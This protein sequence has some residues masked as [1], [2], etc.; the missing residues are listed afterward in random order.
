MEALEMWLWRRMEK[1]SWKDRISNEVVL[2]RVGVERELINMLR[3]KKKRWIGHVLR[4]D[5]LLKEVIGARLEGNKA[6]GRPRLE[7]LDDLITVLYV[8]MKQKVKDREGW[9][10]YVPWTLGSTLRERIIVDIIIMIH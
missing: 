5:G 6:R 4:G 3:N 10:D 8:D 1:V 7:M 9:K 2:G